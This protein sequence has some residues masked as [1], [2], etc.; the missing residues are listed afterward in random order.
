MGKETTLFKSEERKSRAE[1]C[2]VLRKLA[3]QIESGKVTLRQGNEETV[4]EMPEL[5][6]LEV[7]AEDEQKSDKDVQHSLEVELKWW[8]GI[9][10]EGGGGLS[11]D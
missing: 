9:E 5:L 6:E 2:D 1:I 8:D 3:D 4:L 10:A 7:K 11:L